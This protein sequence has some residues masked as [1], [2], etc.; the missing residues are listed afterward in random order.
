MCS[1]KENASRFVWS[2]FDKM[3]MWKYYMDNNTKRPQRGRKISNWGDHNLKF[4]STLITYDVFILST[5]KLP[6]QIES[7]ASSTIKSVQAIPKPLLTSLN[8]ATIL[9]AASILGLYTWEWGWT[10]SDRAER[11]LKENPIVVIIVMWDCNL[12]AAPL[13]LLCVF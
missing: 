8:L 3:S 4:K 6:S 2:L 5:W 12:L 9:D 7:I 13:S 10:P 1:S 11:E